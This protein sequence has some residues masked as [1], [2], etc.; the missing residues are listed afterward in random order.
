MKRSTFLR[1]ALAWPLLGAAGLTQ[2]Q[3]PALPGSIKVLVG[4]PPGGA[5]D[6]IA[7]AFAEQLRAQTG[8]TVVV[9]NRAGA[10]GKLAVDA[11]LQAPAD[12]ATVTVMPASALIL[13]P[14]LV[15]SARYDVARDF[16]TLGSVAQY[17][18]GFGA[19]PMAQSVD[20]EQFK[21]WVKAHPDKAS[22]ATPGVGTPQHFLG[23]QLGQL[24]GAS[25]NHIP[26]K[27]GANALSDVLG[28]QVALLVTTE[29]L[30]VPHHQQGKLRTLM[31]T[32][33]ERNPKMPDVPTVRE[34]GHPHL[35]AH[36]WFGV[37]ARAGT[38]ANRVDPWRDAIARVAAAPGYTQAITQQG[39]SLSRGGWQ[40]LPQQLERE[41]A[42]WAERVRVSGFTAAD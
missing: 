6:V 8:A 20:F 33:R 13:V 27:G 25:M 10:A 7:R 31:V 5:P 21:A 17:G 15:K 11:L 39:Y 34:L 32:S 37:F 23:A 24:A 40:E 16:V 22:Y 38:P 26:Y 3:S 4:F 36:D 19:G 29:Q 30:L 42:A 9:E 12:G 1:H 2:A 41:R 28:G 14:M 18:F 35:E